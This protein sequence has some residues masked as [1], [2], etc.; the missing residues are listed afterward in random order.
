MLSCQSGKGDVD[1]VPLPDS[2]MVP[3]FT[4]ALVL[5]AAFADTYKSK[6][7]SIATV[8][9]D[10]LSKKYGISKAEFQKNMD[11]VHRDPIRLDSI[12]Q[13]VIKHI[14][15]LES[16]FIDVRASNL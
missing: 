15:K 10:Q 3:L 5:N 16:E 2:I 7:D 12:V 11:F 8:Y 4:D 1:F 6:K 14:D 9:S 13:A